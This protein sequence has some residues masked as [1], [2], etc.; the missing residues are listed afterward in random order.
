MIQLCRATEGAQSRAASR[1]RGRR[2]VAGDL[3]N[4]GENLRRELGHD[5]KRLQVLLQLGGHCRAEND[6]TSVRVAD[7]PCLIYYKNQRM[8]EDVK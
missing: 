8:Y 1:R 4:A 6:A 2:L 7:D 5:L 3:V